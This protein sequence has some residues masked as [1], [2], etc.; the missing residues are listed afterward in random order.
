MAQTIR[1]QLIEAVEARL[2]TVAAF[3]GRI[4]PWRRTPLSLAEVPC[5]V[6]LDRDAAVRYE[7][8]EMG[9]GEHLLTI[10]IEGYAKGSTTAVQARSMLGDIVAAVWQDPRWGGLARWTTIDSHEL[11]LE[12]AEEIVGGIKVQITI[13]YRAPLGSI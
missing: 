7:G 4:Y 3:Q 10:D 11:A 9:K 6:I 2:G 5:A 1:Q 12:H 8:V 13:T